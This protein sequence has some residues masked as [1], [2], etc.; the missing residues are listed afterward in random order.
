MEEP[1][2]QTL[3]ILTAENRTNLLETIL[4]RVFEISLK[5]LSKEFSGGPVILGLAD[6]SRNR[7]WEDLFDEYQSSSREEVKAFFDALIYYFHGRLQKS[8]ESQFLKSVEVV[9][10]TKDAVDSNANQKIALSRLA[11]QL[12]NAK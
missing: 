10:Q 4:S 3:F 1:P 11:M 6:Y 12:R 5:P 2:P 9:L 7:N 8:G